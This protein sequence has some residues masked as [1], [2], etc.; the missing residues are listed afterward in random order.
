M[1]DTDRIL[2]DLCHVLRQTAHRP[3]QTYAAFLF[4]LDTQSANDGRS[5][6]LGSNRRRSHSSG[7]CLTSKLQ[8]TCAKLFP[9]WFCAMH[10]RSSLGMFCLCNEAAY[11][12]CWNISSNY[13]EATCM[14][15]SH[16]LL[17]PLVAAIQ[18]QGQPL[19]LD[20][21]CCL[22]N[23]T[24]AASKKSLDLEARQRS[25]EN[26]V[27]VCRYVFSSTKSQPS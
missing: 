16:G 12:I 25:A 17:P 9:L 1:S 21:F 23:K 8:R 22:R 19:S 27:R 15:L 3:L 14:K 11:D 18:A 7:H 5:A 26:N 13:I 6:H 2:S 4:R 20:H 10:L 24:R